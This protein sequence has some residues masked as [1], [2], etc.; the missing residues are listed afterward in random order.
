MARYRHINGRLVEVSRETLG[1][2]LHVMP[3]IRPYKN[4]I[5]GRIITSRSEHRQ[6][7]RDHGCVEIGN[8]KMDPPAPV[9]SN[10]RR[11]VLHRQLG[12]MSDRQA[13]KIIQQLRRHAQ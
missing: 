5:N 6:L 8:E 12:D 1:P 4:M 7:L 9:Q 3:D 10:C 11:E 13:D 2:R